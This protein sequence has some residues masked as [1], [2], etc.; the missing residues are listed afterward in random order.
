M[1]ILGGRLPQRGAPE[2][3]QQRSTVARG[4]GNAFGGG[5]VWRLSRRG[6]GVR[7]A[8]GSCGDRGSEQ[9]V[10]ASDEVLSVCTYFR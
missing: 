3:Q 9:K 4:R 1:D 7:G 2:G 8:Q 10:Q 5:A 6:L